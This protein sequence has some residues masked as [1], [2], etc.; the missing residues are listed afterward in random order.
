MDCQIIWNELDARGWHERIN[1]CARI[2]L[3]QSVPYALAAGKIYGQRPRFG[4]IVIGGQE[5]GLVQMMEASVL[6]GAIHAVMIDRGPLWFDGCGTAGHISLFWQEIN[7]Q[8]PSRFMRKRRFIPEMAD[9]M[10]ALSVLKSAG[11]THQEGS[12]YQTLWLNLKSDEGELRAGLKKNWR[13]SLNKAERES[14]NI[15]FDDAGKT[16]EWFVNHYALDKVQRGYSGASVKMMRYLS[17]AFA[18]KKDILIVKAEQNGAPLAAALIFVHEGSATYQA[19]WCNDAGRSVCANHLLLWQ[20]A[21]ALKTRGVTD[22]DLG[23]VNDE[24]AAGVKKFKEGL[25]GEHQTLPGI[26]S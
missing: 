17:H 2:P 26:F 8:F 18:I 10:A 16:I 7:R 24:S 19:G 9:G 11:L 4:V 3:T 15:E 14:I 20:C 25:H 13:G 6:W 5:A 12:A 23:G 21:L 1:R 22:F